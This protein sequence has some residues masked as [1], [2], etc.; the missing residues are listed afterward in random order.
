MNLNLCI[1][2]VA[3]AVASGPLCDVETASPTN[4]AYVS[5]KLAQ[6]ALFQVAGN[7]TKPLFVAIKSSSRAVMTFV[8]PSSRKAIASIHCDDMPMPVNVGKTR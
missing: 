7:T 8:P 3:I 6:A 2:V 4:V 1:A 5:D